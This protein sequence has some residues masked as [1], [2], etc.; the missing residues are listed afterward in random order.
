M[1]PINAISILKKRSEFLSVAAHRQRWVTPAFILQIAPRQEEGAPLDVLGLG[2]TASKKMIGN[3]V[4]RNRARRRL[5]ALARELLPL[6]AQAGINYIFI[7]RQ[8]ILT[9]S[10]DALRKDG[11]WALKRLNVRK[12]L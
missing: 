1:P 7:A 2:L 4:C 9:R 5:R 11:L 10:Y 8:D 6:Y 12:D 3:A